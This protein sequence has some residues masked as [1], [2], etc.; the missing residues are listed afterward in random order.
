MKRFPIGE[1]VGPTNRVDPPLSSHLKMA[2]FLRLKL[3]PRISPTMS[4]FFRLTNLVRFFNVTRNTKKNIPGKGA[5]SKDPVQIDLPYTQLLRD[6]TL[7]SLLLSQDLDGCQ[8]VRVDRPGETAGKLITVLVHRAKSYFTKRSPAP[9]PPKK[10]QTAK[11]PSSS[12]VTNT[13]GPSDDQQ[14]VMSFQ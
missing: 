4:S 2:S 11:N 6:P 8:E 7:S 14:K 13:P 5:S 1:V 12:K 10:K 9:T 3:S